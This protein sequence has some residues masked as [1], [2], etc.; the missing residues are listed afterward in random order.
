MEMPD[1]R[2]P[3]KIIQPFSYQQSNGSCW[4]TSVHNGLLS[5][6]GS[7]DKIEHFISRMFYVITSAE[8]TDNQEAE[9]LVKL[10][11]ENKMVCVKGSVIRE[12]HITETRLRRLLKKKNSVL[13][14]DTLSGIH[15]ILLLGLVRDDI[16]AFDP[17]WRH[18]KDCKIVKGSFVCCPYTT[19]NGTLVFNPY[20]NVHINIHHFL[21][22]RTLAAKDQRFVM[23]AGSSRFIIELV[24]M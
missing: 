13:I 22:A 5:L 19:E 20:Y 21:K 7:S 6:L 12:D 24:K 11:N 8:G 3:K 14:A 17:D 16:I 1:N 23:G 10:I 9:I 2:M 15:S 18:V 4:I